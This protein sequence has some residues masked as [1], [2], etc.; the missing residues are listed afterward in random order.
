[1]VFLDFSYDFSYEFSSDRFFVTD[2]GILRAFLEGGFLRR[3]ES[4][5]FLEEIYNFEESFF[6]DFLFLQGLL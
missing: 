6:F 4:E 2:T 5:F 1:M 3:G